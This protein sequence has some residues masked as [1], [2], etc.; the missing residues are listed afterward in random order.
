VQGLLAVSGPWAE[1]PRREQAIPVAEYLRDRREDPGV[2]PGGVEDLLLEEVFP[3]MEPPA[4]LLSGG[5]QLLQ[6]GPHR[7]DA[8]EFDDPRQG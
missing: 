8:P 7:P 2:A 5:V 6:A 3:D 4:A 1:R